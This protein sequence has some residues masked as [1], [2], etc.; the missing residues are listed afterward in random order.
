[1]LQDKRNIVLDKSVLVKS[2][3]EHYVNIVEKS[4]GKNLQMFHKNITI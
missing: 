1:M 2:F 4:C 3:N